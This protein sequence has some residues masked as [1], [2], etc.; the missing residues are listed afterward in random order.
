MHAYI[1]SWNVRLWL[2]NFLLFLLLL[3]VAI[4]VYYGTQCSVIGMASGDAKQTS[5]SN[6]DVL[7]LL[8]S[9]L[10]LLALLTTWNKIAFKNVPTMFGGSS[11]SVA[12][13]AHRGAAAA[14]SAINGRS[15][16]TVREHHL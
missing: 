13:S 4:L 3:F 10:L 12:R 15:V 16:R 14:T 7:R 6:I 8:F 5:T 9:L 11:A 1:R 2:L